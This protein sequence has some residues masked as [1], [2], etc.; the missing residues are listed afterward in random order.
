MKFKTDGPL[1]HQHA[2]IYIE[3]PIIIQVIRCLH[4]MTYLA[5][6]APRQQ[7]I[8]S[9]ISHLSRHPSL[10]NYVFLYV[11]FDDLSYND[12]KIWYQTMG[13]RILRQLR[14]LL[15]NGSLELSTRV[16]NNSVGWGSFLADMSLVAKKC[17]KNIVIVIDR[18]DIIDRLTTS[19]FDW[20]D[21]F[22]AELRAIHNERPFQQ[23]FKRITFIF[24]G[25]YNPRTL[26]SDPIISPFNIASHIYLQDFTEEQVYQLVSKGDWGMNQ[27][28]SLAQRIHYW[29]DGQPYLTQLFCTL[30]DSGATFRDVDELAKQLVINNISHF[31]KLRGQLEGNS[32]LATYVN[33]IVSGNR[34]KFNRENPVQTQLELLGVIKANEDGY[35]IMRNRIYQ[36]VLY[37]DVIIDAIEGRTEQFNSSD[38]SL[39]QL[40]APPIANTEQTQQDIQIQ[41]LVLISYHFN[42]AELKDLCFRMGV[43]YEDL[44]AAGK[45]HKARELI[46]H[47][48]RRNRLIE[49]TKECQNLRPGVRWPAA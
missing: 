11:S 33:G 6:I 26:I 18:I 48:E 37:G 40:I 29:T 27:S 1:E 32:K 28:Q 13:T 35:C 2:N 43:E 20:K 22:F 3:P 47:I 16:P 23:E 12:Q 17:N 8:T 49:L 42:E 5:I 38:D 30:L 19:S 34:F 7:G 24:A 31:S 14:Q 41:L 45:V 15:E 36:M 46:T 44:A 25:T 10:Y 21:S 39:N 9:L 4:E